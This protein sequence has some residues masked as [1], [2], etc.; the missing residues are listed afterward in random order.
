VR[1]ALSLTI[2]IRAVNQ[3]GRVGFELSRLDQFN[4]LKEIGLDLIRSG[5]GRVGSGSG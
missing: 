1:K 3:A 4:L 5:L 2:L